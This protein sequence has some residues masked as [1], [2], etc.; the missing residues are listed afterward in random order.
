MTTLLISVLIII[1]LVI[2]VSKMKKEDRKNVRAR[3]Y[4]KTP[5]KSQ[6]HFRRLDGGSPGMIVLYI[7]LVLFFIG[8]FGGIWHISSKDKTNRYWNR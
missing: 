8:I 2:V 4:R 5:R 6:E 7:F 3:R 1:I